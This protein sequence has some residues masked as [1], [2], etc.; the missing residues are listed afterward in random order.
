MEKNTFLNSSC[1]K[2]IKNKKALS[3]VIS[4]LLFILLTLVLVGIIWATVKKITEDKIDTA[5][6]CYEISDKVFINE[7]K[8]TCFDYN[9]VGKVSL[10]ITLKEVDLD[11]LI[12]TVSKDAESKSFEIAPNNFPAYITSRAGGTA[13]F[14]GENTGKTYL[15][16]TSANGLG[17]PSEGDDIYSIKLSPVVNGNSCGVTSSYLNIPNCNEFN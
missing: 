4:T 11:K 14:P 16:D 10:S 13:E 2:T 8:Y 12:I 3:T 7:D 9:I 6:S 17:L 15:I 5:E 1:V